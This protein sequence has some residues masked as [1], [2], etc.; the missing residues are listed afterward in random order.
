MASL[1]VLWYHFSSTNAVRRPAHDGRGERAE[2]ERR[3]GGAADDGLEVDARVAVQK[4]LLGIGLGRHGS[5]RGHSCDQ[6]LCLQ[7]SSKVSGFGRA[8][9]NS[10]RGRDS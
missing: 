9:M 8:L 4:R 6:C 5:V 10:V 3:D 1:K 2:D 7:E